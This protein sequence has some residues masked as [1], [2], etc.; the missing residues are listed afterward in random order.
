ML[1][2]LLGHVVMNT[3]GVNACEPQDDTHAVSLTVTVTG[4]GRVATQRGLAQL[5]L[6]AVFIKPEHRHS[7]SSSSALTHSP[8][9]AQQSANHP[10]L[11]LSLSLC[12]SSLHQY[13]PEQNHTG[14]E[15]IDEAPVRISTLKPLYQAPALRIYAS[16]YF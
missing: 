7:L 6:R 16:T 8:S 5:R 1:H 15:S 11:I 13:S 12:H 3:I 14:P 4:T 10:S 2:I 9:Q